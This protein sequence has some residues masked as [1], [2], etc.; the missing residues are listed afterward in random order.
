MGI[1]RAVWLALLVSV[2]GVASGPVQESGAAATTPTVTVTTNKT[3]YRPGDALTVSVSLANP[4]VSRS[5]D[6]YFGVQLQ[7]S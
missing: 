6:A 5:V 3:A 4:G 2:P 7:N 1:S